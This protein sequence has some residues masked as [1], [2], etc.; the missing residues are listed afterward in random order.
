MRGWSKESVPCSGMFVQVLC[1]AVGLM[2]E[3][4]ADCASVADGTVRGWEIAL[5]SSKPPHFRLGGELREKFCLVGMMNEC[6]DICING[7]EAV[8]KGEG[9]DVERCAYMMC[10]AA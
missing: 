1:P 7:V 5:V 8:V 4:V 10:G 6:G 3:E 2:C 9:M